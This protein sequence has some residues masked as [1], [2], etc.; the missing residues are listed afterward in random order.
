VSK[1]V[2][3]YRCAVLRG[4]DAKGCPCAFR[5]REARDHQGIDVPQCVVCLSQD[6]IGRGCGAL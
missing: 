3:A 6:V 5:L 1:L 4:R 2:S